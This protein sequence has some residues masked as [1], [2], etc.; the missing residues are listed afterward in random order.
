[1][2]SGAKPDRL[3]LEYAGS[4]E[5]AREYPR[6]PLP[7]VAVAG[8]SN[9]GKSSLL[10][11]IGG[12]SDLARVSKTPGRTQRIHFFQDATLGLAVVDLPGYGFA[13]V[14]KQDRARFAAAVDAYLTSRPNLRGLVLLLD[15]RRSPEDEE[16]MLAEFA[17]SRGIG[18]VVVA[19]KID[20]LNRAERSRRLR[21]LDEAGFG[22]WLPFSSIT[23]EGREEVVRALRALVSGQMENPGQV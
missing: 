18:L 23:R 20:K 22:R 9:C 10:N 21:E 16:R 19:T 3:R 2:G 13:R 12:R 1:M 15:A 7:E 11:V 8:R 4:A 17:T 6:W 5:L 14:S